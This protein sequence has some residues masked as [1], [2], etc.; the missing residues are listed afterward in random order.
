M[1]VGTEAAQGLA[2]QIAFPPYARELSSP[3][4]NGGRSPSRVAASARGSVHLPVSESEEALIRTIC[5]CAVLTQSAPAAASSRIGVP[6]IENS[7]TMRFDRAL[8]R[9]MVKAE[10]PRTPSTQIQLAVAVTPKGSDRRGP[11]STT[12]RASRIW[13]AVTTSRESGSIAATDRGGAT[14]PPPP[15]RVRASAVAATTAAATRAAPPMTSRRP[16]RRRRLLTASRDGASPSA[17]RASS[18][19]LL[20]VGYRSAGSFASARARTGSSLG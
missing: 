20:Q 14:I 9:E 19:K 17:A 7:R 16:I 3:A 13:I 11:P 1:L 12:P 2:A 18:T 5:L 10:P 15:S 4:P 8:I 6:V